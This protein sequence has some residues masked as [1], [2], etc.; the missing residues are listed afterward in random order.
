M[1]LISHS[2]YSYSL[3]PSFILVR[4]AELTKLKESHTGELESAFQQ[5]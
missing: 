1:T 5:L 2:R 3:E 4:H